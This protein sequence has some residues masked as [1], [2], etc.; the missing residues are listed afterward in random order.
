[1]LNDTFKHLS[2]NLSFSKIANK[3]HNIS[4]NRNLMIQRSV[5][6]S[7]KTCAKVSLASRVVYTTQ[8]NINTTNYN[9][10]LATENKCTNNNTKLKTK[11][12]LSKPIKSPIKKNKKTEKLS[13]SNFMSDMWLSSKPNYFKSKLLVEKIKKKIIDSSNNLANLAIR[14][15]S[16]SQLKKKSDV[17]HL[18]LIKKAIINNK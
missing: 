18:A 6:Y 14:P 15:K 3:S 12:K 10:N 16:L 4:P 17:P 9:S 7:N 13:K 8:T 5:K 11:N 1:M 2:N